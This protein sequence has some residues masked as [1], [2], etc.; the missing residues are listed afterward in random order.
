MTHDAP[1]RDTHAVPWSKWLG[2]TLAGLLLIGGTILVFLAFDRHSHWNSDTLRP[3]LIT[4]V[5]V[6]VIA[7]L[8]AR[9]WPRR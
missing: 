9:S 3:F 2:L 1:D 8:G 4:T 7:L 6:W 5:P